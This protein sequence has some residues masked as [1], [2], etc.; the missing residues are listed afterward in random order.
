MSR[1][2]L[3]RLTVVVSLLLLSTGCSSGEH[4]KSQPRYVSRIVFAKGEKNL[5]A[6]RDG[7]HERFLVRGEEPEISPDGHWVAFYPCNACSLYVINA[8]GGRMR[9]LAKN[10]DPPSWSPDS[11][12]LATVGLTAAPTYDE[13]LVTVDRTTGKQCRIAVAPRI[14]GFDFSPDGKR[15][16]FAMSTSDE[17]SDVY[18]SARDGG[19]LRRL[20]WDDRSSR[21]LWGPDGSIAY[22][23]REGPLGPFFHDQVWGKH[24][25]WRIFRDGTGRRVLTATIEAGRYGRPDGPEGRGVVSRRWN[26]PRSESDP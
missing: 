17:D 22:S 11:R 23:R 20:T 25:I 3:R 14:L 26:S 2:R 21:P 18:V 19:A 6:D 24:R 16:T 7:R 10:V 1:M 5:V 13:Q 9:L 4:P 8:D 12:H 15:L